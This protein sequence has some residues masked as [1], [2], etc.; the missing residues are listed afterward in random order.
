[1]K[2]W[3]PMEYP[4]FGGL[5][6]Q[7][8]F[9]WEEKMI[10]ALRINKVPAVDQVAKIRDNLS[11]HPLGMVPESTKLAKDAFST[12]KG[13]YGDEDRLMMLRLKELRKMGPKPE[14]YSTQVIW[15]TDLIGKLQRLV[16]VADMDE[17]LAVEVFTKDVFTTIMNLF[18]AKEHLKL[19]KAGFTY[20]RRSKERM[21]DILRS[22]FLLLIKAVASASSLRSREA[23]P[24]S[25]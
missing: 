6:S 23:R 15:L 21:D 2:L 8:Y 4:Q 20:G 18:S 17:D 5:D 12:L 11:L 13:R 9:E 10:R 7:C 25:S 16:E 19:S 24:T 1:M 14:K 3:S 22:Y